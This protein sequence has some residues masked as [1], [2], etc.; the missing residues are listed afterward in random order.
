MDLT[1]V[2][3][4]GCLI[5]PVL[6]P[7]FPAILV[8]AFIMGGASNS[9]YSLV[10]AYVNDYLESEDMAAASAGLIMLNGIGAMGAPILLGY[11]M[12]LIV[13]DVFFLFLAF[14]FG[15]VMVYAIWRQRQRPVRIVV[16]EQ[17][18]V[19]PMSQVASPLAADVAIEA[20]LEQAELE[21]AELE[22][23]ETPEAEMPGSDI[24]RT[25]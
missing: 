22:Q 5:V 16:G 20:A 10:V 13:D 19:V 17:G 14:A 11:L 23:A 1:G 18:P 21:Q 6:G 15:S 12:D 8:A 3:A 7:S 24:S 2:G 25:D 9:L 4:L